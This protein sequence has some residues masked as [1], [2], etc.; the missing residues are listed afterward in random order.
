M[1]TEQPVGLSC[2]GCGQ[3]P[4]A[5]MRGGTQAF[6]GNEDDCHVFSWNPQLTLTEIAELAQVIDLR[7][8]E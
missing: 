5:V 3:P 8:F 1:T 2:P 6:C 7:E 4:W